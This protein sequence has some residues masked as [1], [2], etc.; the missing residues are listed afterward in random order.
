[1]SLHAL[2]AQGNVLPSRRPTQHH[3]IRAG[4]GPKHSSMSPALKG[5]LKRFELVEG[6]RP[7]RSQ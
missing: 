2:R 6:A 4:C 7:V 3:Q 1:M 5:T